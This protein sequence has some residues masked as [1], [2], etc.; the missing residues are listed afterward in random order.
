MKWYVYALNNY[1]NFKG[2]ATRSEFWWFTLFYFIFACVCA[3]LDGLLNAGFFYSIYFLVTLIP[4]ISVTARRLHD[5]GHSG[6][7]MLIPI[8]PI[9]WCCQKSDEGDNAY[10]SPFNVMDEP[11]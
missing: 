11:R 1:A 9:I 6:W 7:L 3:F 5:T 10:G 8:V 2:R 4:S